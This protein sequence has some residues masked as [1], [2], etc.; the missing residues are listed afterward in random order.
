MTDITNNPTN[1]WVAMPRDSDFPIQNLPYGVFRH[2]SAGPRIGV[3]IGDYVLDLAA[4]HEAGLFGSTSIADDNLFAHDSLNRFMARGHQTWS[5]VRGRIIE[6][7]RA[8]NPEL[9]DNRRLREAALISRDGVQMLLPAAIGDFVDFYSSREHATNAGTLFRGAQNA[10]PPNWL[11]LPI[12]YHGRAGSIVVSP[13]DIRRPH[14]QIRPNPDAPPILAASRRLDFELELGFFAGVG[15]RAGV[16]ISTGEADKHIFGAVLLNDWSARDVQQWEYQPL[17]PFLG[18]SF[19][20]TISPWVVP[21]EA[22]KP[23]RVIGP[24]Q[25]PPVLDYLRFEGAWNF[26]INLEVW[27]GTT[28]TTDLF[29]ITA[30]NSRKLYWNVAQHL[31]HATIN[32]ARV[33][34]GDLFASGTVSGTT[35]DSLGSLLEISKNGKEPMFLPNS[36][37]RAFLEDGDTVKLRGW[38]QGDGYRIGFGDCIGRILD[39]A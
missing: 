19:A 26:D 29:Q 37:R 2:K 15:N 8:D 9:R 5:E 11:Y 33:R 14:G 1:S 3:A 27:L 6:L 4:L 32:G 20:T 16:P 24:D 38:C 17:G 12:A 31:A 28:A 35:P 18:K 39:T 10:L 30:V 25:E 13:H 7:L 23:F 36:E 22:L 21:L 34:S